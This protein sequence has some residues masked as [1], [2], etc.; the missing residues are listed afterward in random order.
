MVE[1]LQ[2]ACGRAERAHALLELRRVDRVDQPDAP[3]DGERVRGAL[4]EL[5]LSPAE[6]TLPLVNQLPAHVAP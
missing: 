6:A 4:H 5:V 2:H 1:E 3:F